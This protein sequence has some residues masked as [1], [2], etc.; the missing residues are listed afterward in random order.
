M[1]S[2]KL[3]S[4]STKMDNDALTVEAKAVLTHEDFTMDFSNVI[5]MR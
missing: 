4:L 5:S 2:Y 3:G 1:L